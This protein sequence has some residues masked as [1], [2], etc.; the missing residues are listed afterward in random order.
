MRNI[1]EE[2]INYLS[3]LEQYEKI[4]N[5]QKKNS[6]FFE[7]DNIRDILTHYE[8]LSK[9]Q[10][11]PYWYDMKSIFQKEGKM[12]NY[13]QFEEFYDDQVE[14]FKKLLG[15]QTYQSLK[16]VYNLQFRTQ[17][18]QGTI[19]EGPKII[20]F[21]GYIREVQEFNNTLYEQKT[22]KINDF[23]GELFGIMSSENSM[24]STS[25]IWPTL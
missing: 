17:A 20:F 15:E 11:N 19:I 25:L 14:T 4:T 24:K 2:M 7:A 10:F 5:M 1:N 13:K 16:E 12:N 22:F 23:S 8:D 18:P 9:G 21:E 6:Q 3:K